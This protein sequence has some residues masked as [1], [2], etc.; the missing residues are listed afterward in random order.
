MVAS[1]MR[2]R[3]TPGSKT[4]NVARFFRSAIRTEI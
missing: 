2:M 3:D 1:D 4:S